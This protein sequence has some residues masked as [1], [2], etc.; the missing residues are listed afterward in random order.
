MLPSSQI[1]EITIK[2]YLIIVRR[3][4]WIILS[5]F[6]LV[7]V[8]S[9]VQSL[10]KIPVYQANAKVI[11]ETM[12]PRV[13]PLPEIYPTK[14][15]D[16]EYMRTQLSIIK[17]RSLA[18]KTV[19]YLIS[20]GESKFL[21]SKDPAGAFVGGV[22]V[23]PIEGTQIIQ[24]GYTGSDPLEVT[25]FANALAQCYIQLDIASK[26]S[27]LVSAE[28]WL[29]SGLEE[30]N[31][32]LQRAESALIDYIQKNE[33]LSVPDIEKK[34][35]SLLEGLRQQRLNAQSEISA[36]LGRYKEK[37][38]QV[39]ILKTKLQSIE[40]AIQK[41]TAD[42]V[43]MREKMVEYNILKREVETNRNLYE[44]LL[45]T[46][47][48]TKISKELTTTNLRIL[49]LAQIPSTP[50]SPDHKRDIST[51]ILW[52]LVLGLGVAF[53]IEYL[54]ST[55]KNAEDVETYVKLPFLGYLPS[56]GIEDE[57]RV[58]RD[59]DLVSQRLPN[60][61]VAEAYRSI[62][63]SIIFSAPEDRPLKTILIT[64]SMPQEGKTFISINLG[65]IFANVKE[66]ILIL[67]ADMR[68][69]RIYSVFN[70]DNDVG[71]SSLLAGEAGLD[72][73]IRAV[74][75][76]N[77]YLISSGPIPPNPAELLSSTKFPEVVDELKKRFDRIIIDTPPVLSVADASIL[78]NVADGVIEVIRANS[79]TIVPVL[80]AKQRL[81]EAK[82]RVIGVILNKVNVKRE[83]SYYYYHY[84]YRKYKRT[85]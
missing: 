61:R 22:I 29:E 80:R 76:P 5:I 4:I 21:G 50:I 2:D 28:K 83:D 72:E 75:V 30:M 84:Y 45:K 41:E 58:I 38:P 27:G 66:K 23:S 46:T 40:E 79:T 73:V 54:D 56:L 53:F 43:Q 9:L 44:Q 62:R 77:L 68:R 20:I 11:I 14:L 32:K 85:S 69:P 60:S 33:I 47:K 71:L 15:W 42:L 12:T 51:G 59:S 63:T 1:R 19:N 37:H 81:E 57:I 70:M 34:S 3:R 8:Y 82:A 18:E 10:K 65:I 26:V 55:L 17:S 6:I 78:A 16:K 31:Q 35:Q 49:E 13:S 25:K 52:G 7:A 67:E 74:S 36:S 48:E 64:S 24:I 39:V